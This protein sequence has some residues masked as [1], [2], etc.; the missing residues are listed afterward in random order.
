MKS[1]LFKIL[2]IVLPLLAGI[3]I[4]TVVD[5]KLADKLPGYEGPVSPGLSTKKIAW[6]LAVF[7]VGN[8]AFHFIV[9]KLNLKNLR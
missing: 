6:F 2:H 4:A 3:G 7:A 9:K 1:L 8:I 5:N